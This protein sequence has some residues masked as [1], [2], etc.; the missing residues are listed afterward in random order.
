MNATKLTLHTATFDRGLCLYYGHLDTLLWS[1]AGKLCQHCTNPRSRRKLG[2]FP[3]L[4]RYSSAAAVPLRLPSV[5]RVAKK[6]R[7]DSVGNETE[8][9]MDDFVE[10]GVFPPAGIRAVSV[11][12]GVSDQRSGIMP[13]RDPR[14]GRAA[15]SARR[16]GAEVNVV[17]LID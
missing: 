7:A 2:M 3:S 8:V 4:K 13:R 5:A 17:P 1:M 14:G 11:G 9:A 12:D 6:M 16:S 15:S 10:I